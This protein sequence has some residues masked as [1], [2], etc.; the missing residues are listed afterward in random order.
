MRAVI[1][2]CTVSGTGLS[3]NILQ[4]ECFLDNAFIFRVIFFNSMKL[5]KYWFE[6]VSNCVKTYAL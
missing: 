1:C 5:P 6:K 4:K 2:K 3:N